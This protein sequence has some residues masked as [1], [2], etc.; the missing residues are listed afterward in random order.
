MS[1]VFDQFHDEHW[2]NQNVIRGSDCHDSLQANEGKPFKVLNCSVNVDARVLLKSLDYHLCG[3][4]SIGCKEILGDA[5]LCVIGGKANACRCLD[6]SREVAIRQN[7]IGT[8]KY[9]SVD[10]V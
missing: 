2:L 5:L 9:R 8:V 6:N 3:I 10:V 7:R 1:T 4:D